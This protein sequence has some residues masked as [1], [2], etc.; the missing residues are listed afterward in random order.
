MKKKLLTLVLAT[1]QFV[2][3]AQTVNLHFKNGQIIEFPSSN[4]DYVDFSVKASDPFVSGEEA[5]DLGLSVYW[6]SCNLGATKPEE[7]GEYYAWGE[8]KSKDK[9]QCFLNNY[10]YYD[11]NT[12]QYIH[13]GDDISD[14]EYDAA[15]VNLG[16][17]WRMTTY[18]EIDELAKNC[19]WEWTQINEV[20]GFKI[21]GSNGNSIFL[22]AAGLKAEG[23]DMLFNEGSYYWG[24]AYI[25]SWSASGSRATAFGG[26]SGSQSNIFFSPRYYGYTIRPVK[27]KSN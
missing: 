14:T 19:S 27:S 9:S 15:R 22:P 21:T 17:N 4:V 7:S 12:K 5:V 20:N 23:L 18:T 25:E 24:A 11:D 10:S 8:T 13:I 6:A 26:G 3:F 1:I 16:D 2:S